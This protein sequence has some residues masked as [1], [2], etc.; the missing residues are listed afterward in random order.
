MGVSPA[1]AFLGG[2]A[3]ARL[4][5]FGCLRLSLTRRARSGGRV[6]SVWQRARA[7]WND[8]ME[9]RDKADRCSGASCDT[10]APKEHFERVDAGES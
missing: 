8:F 10:R 5:K 3:L 7:S 6:D 4:R 2:C 1:I 9:A